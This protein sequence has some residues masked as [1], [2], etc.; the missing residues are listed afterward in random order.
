VHENGVLSELR[1]PVDAAPTGPHGYWYSRWL[2]E[3]AL[4][5]IYFVAFLVAL[6]Q[7][8][9]LLG[10][11]GLLP[12][13]E[14]VAHMPFRASPS[15][16]YLFPTD[17]AFR[18]AAWLGLAVSLLPLTGV[19]SRAGSWPSAAVWTVL[20]L[21]YLSF[22]NVGQTFYGFG[23]ETLLLETGFLAIFLGGRSTDPGTVITWLLRWLLFRLMFG[24]GLIKWRGDPC[25]HDLTCL[26]YY[27]ETQPIPN[28][29]TW[30]FH[31]LPASVHH[32][33]VVINH[34]V[35]LGVPFLYFAPQP[36]AAA[37]GLLTIAFQLILIASGN[38]SWLNWLTIVLAIP[39]LHDRWLDWLPVRPPALQRPTA[40]RRASLYALA[41]LVGLLSVA[42]TL[43]MLSP[44]QVM[45]TSFDP[46]HLVNTYG[47]FGSITKERREIVIEGTDDAEITG[48]TRWREY[49]FKGKP[50]DPSRMPAQVA[51]Y[52]LRLD[53]LMW[54]AAMSQ[55][56]DYE[57]FAPL[58]VKLLQG[59]APTLGLLGRNPFPDRPPRYVRAQY[60][61]YHL[62]SPAERRMTGRWWTRELIGAYYPAV[63]L[64]SP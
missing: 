8:V 31:W 57:W 12:V 39:T 40:A 22:V 43:N 16:F 35:E 3:R 29:L 49:E 55:P 47:A 11:Y 52:H 58:L 64:R 36:I 17:G 38:L 61:R 46:L 45:N 33:G 15:L 24:A 10:E 5:L 4:A 42:P 25:W 50:G 53:W 13:R 60:Y 48:A 1:S 30:Y 56:S 44:A 32:A 37:A 7:F 28:P 27:F 41:V 18:T 59:D 62:T 19:A 23:W 51:P 26:D 34:V 14:W 2:F 63:S 54:F 9:P 6:N 20:W 21:L